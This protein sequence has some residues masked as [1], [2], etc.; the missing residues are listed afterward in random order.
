MAR[1]TA[2]VATALA[3]L[4]SGCADGSLGSGFTTGSINP[5]NETKQAEARSKEALCLTLTSQIEA[6]NS[7]GIS[8]K[9]SKA[10]AKKYKLKSGDLAKADELNKANTEFQA[11]C[12]SYPPRNVAEIEPKAD[13]AATTKAAATPPLPT[14]KSD[15]QADKS[16]SADA[17]PARTAAATGTQVPG[18]STTASTP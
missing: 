9:V 14:Q 2:L 11:K 17:S 5:A 12:S 10:A 4:L 3:C 6:L 13:A 8:E 7:E 16:A 15:A 1:S 18:E